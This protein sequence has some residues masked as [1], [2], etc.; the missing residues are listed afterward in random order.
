MCSVLC[1]FQIEEQRSHMSIVLLC[2]LSQILNVFNNRLT[3]KKKKATGEFSSLDDT[4]GREE[5]NDIFKCE[6]N[7]L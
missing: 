4:E 6:G 1:N 7:G 5:A 3:G 2:N